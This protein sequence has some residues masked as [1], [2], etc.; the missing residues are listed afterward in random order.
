MVAACSYSRLVMLEAL[1]AATGFVVIAI[2]ASLANIGFRQVR[3]VRQWWPLLCFT[4]A[5]PD[6]AA[7]CRRSC[8][9]PSPRNPT[10]AT[11]RPRSTNSK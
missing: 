7:W 3:G 8:A 4:P 5:V 6:R 9:R 10:M 2:A 1:V 11:A